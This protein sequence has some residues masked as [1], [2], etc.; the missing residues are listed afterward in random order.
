M[1]SVAHVT[2]RRRLH[3]THERRPRTIEG[4]RPDRHHHHP[5]RRA[6]VPVGFL[7]SLL[8]T[9][10]PTAIAGNEDPSWDMDRAHASAEGERRLLRYP[11][12]QVWP[13]MIRYLRLDRGY[14]IQEHDREAGY[15]IFEFVLGQDRSGSGQIELFAM[16][17]PAGRP[18]VQ[19]ILRTNAGP[20]HLPYTILE[21]LAGKLR[22]ERGQPAPPPP[23][24]VQPPKPAPPADEPPPDGDAT[25]P[26]QN[27][28]R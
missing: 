13:A 15:V 7:L 1:I 18:S 14:R 10:T 12:D 11:Y 25:Q 5:I 3:T 21:G 27:E 2:G 19:L 28:L 9:P 16:P 26:R 24:P 4:V 20:A 8:V 22:V 6:A 23:K 17:D